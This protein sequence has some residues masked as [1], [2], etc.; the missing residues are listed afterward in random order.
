MPFEI[1][2][3]ESAVRKLIELDR[4]VARRI[5]EKVGELR[6]TPHRHIQKLV[7]SRYYRLRVGDYRV[8]MDIDQ[9]A[10][11]ILILKVGHR[12]SIHER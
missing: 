3:S 7:N 6:E 2:W 8:I 11:R 9:G 10:L 5:F 1:L 12:E 4:T